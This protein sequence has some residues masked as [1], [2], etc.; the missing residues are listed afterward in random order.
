M[1]L[2]TVNLTFCSFV[3]IRER[4]CYMPHPEDPLDKT[5]MRSETVVTV[6]GVPLTDYM[7]KWI[8]LCYL[9]IDFWNH[10]IILKESIIVNTVSRN[11]G[12]GRAAID[13]VVDKLANETKNLSTSLDKL[14]LEIN[15]LRDKVIN[16]WWVAHR[17]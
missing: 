8:L 3:S 7:V 15:G 5:V 14:K 11:A 2:A 1:E 17:I 12:K 13:W 6:Q 4:I 9:K 16:G 10:G